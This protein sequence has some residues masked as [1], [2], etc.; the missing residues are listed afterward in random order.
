MAE[1]QEN[2]DGACLAASNQDRLV[3]LLDQALFLLLTTLSP[4][5]SFD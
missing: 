3:R 5:W 4:T 1:F 2:D